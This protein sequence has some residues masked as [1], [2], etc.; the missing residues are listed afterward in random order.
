ML[1]VPPEGVTR[2]LLQLVAVTEIFA[3]L[4]L[5]AINANE[6]GALVDAYRSAACD[7]T[8]PHVWSAAAHRAQG[9]GS[10]NCG[11]ATA[12]RMPIR[13]IVTTSSISVK[14]ASRSILPNLPGGRRN[15]DRD[16][17]SG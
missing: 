12:A 15:N 11:K 16:S 4:T 7:A 1:D 10:V 2:K 14:P 9:V 6:F 13:T 5:E 17:L 8:T 3:V